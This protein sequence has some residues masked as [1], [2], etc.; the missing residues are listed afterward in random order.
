MLRAGAEAVEP[1]PDF[2]ANFWQK[3][4]ALEKEPWSSRLFREL[5][6]LVPVPS[7]AESFAVL[8]IA[9]LI[10]GA[11]GAFSAVNT[12]TPERLQAERASVR[13]LSGF[14]EFKGLPSPSLAAAYLETGEERVFG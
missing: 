12:L 10:G 5:E 6:S 4:F 7:L 14:S 2:E 13:Y 1:S 9:L 3:V 11:G 8:L